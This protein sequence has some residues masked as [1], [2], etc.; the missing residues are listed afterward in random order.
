MQRACRLAGVKGK[1]ATSPLIP[2]QLL[3]RWVRLAEATQVTYIRE[4]VIRSPTDDGPASSAV[5]EERLIVKGK[6]GRGFRSGVKHMLAD[7]Q[8]GHILTV[9]HRDEETQELV[10]E[11]WDDLEIQLDNGSDKRTYR[12]SEGTIPTA[13]YDRTTEFD[14]VYASLP[15]NDVASWPTRLHN[16]T[17]DHMSAVRARVHAEQ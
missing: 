13:P 11:H 12:L 4:R 3:D 14:G 17:V 16:G 6:A 8:D 9:R 2:P 10:D 1:L 5:A 15:D 7:G